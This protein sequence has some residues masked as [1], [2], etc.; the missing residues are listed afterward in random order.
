M[1]TP[2]HQ[3]DGA[4]MPTPPSS[5]SSES[6]EDA[7]Q[8]VNSS[9]VSKEATTSAA[10]KEKHYMELFRKA[11]KQI[12]DE[13]QK[14]EEL[15]K[16]NAALRALVGGVQKGTA[17]SIVASLRQK[18]LDLSLENFV[19]VEQITQLQLRLSAKTTESVHQ[20]ALSPSKSSPAQQ[21]R[22]NATLGH[23][24]TISPAHLRSRTVSP[25]P[26]SAKGKPRGTSPRQ[27]NSSTP[28]PLRVVE[29]STVPLAGHHFDPMASVEQQRS[30]PR[31]T[32]NIK[33][34][35]AAKNYNEVMLNRLRRAIAPPPTKEQLGE[36]VHAM[37]QELCKSLHSHG[38]HLPMHRLDACLYQCGSRKLHLSV[39]S[40]RLVVKCGGGH[41]DLLEHIERNKMCQRVAA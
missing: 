35:M 10:A 30:P 32:E 1:A 12:R 7:D 28:R 16:E 37:V 34:A 24:R 29:G 41:V 5:V 25:Q 6:E 22:H 2:V 4:T 9:K 15:R 19:A 27:F 26:A 36:V 39:D 11:T 21:Q 33:S 20:V 40:G 3:E 31:A 18:I 8:Q 23:G 13:R 17:S 14:V 38:A